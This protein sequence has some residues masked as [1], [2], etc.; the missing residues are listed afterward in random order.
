MSA[1]R[2]LQRTKGKVHSLFPTASDVCYHFL[3]RQL[4]C[5]LDQ[6]VVNSELIKQESRCCYEGT[7]YM[8]LTSI[9]SDSKGIVMLASI[10]LS[11][12]RKSMLVNVNGA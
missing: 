11:L 5:Q 6:D 1:E 2:Y 7:L 12:S 9:V 3:A 10:I 8:W 4:F